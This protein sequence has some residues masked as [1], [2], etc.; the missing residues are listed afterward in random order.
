MLVGG[1]L[2]RPLVHATLLLA[3]NSFSFEELAQHAVDL[4]AGITDVTTHE[5]VVGGGPSLQAA[6]QNL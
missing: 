2:R 5:L 3:A 1:E 4:V 6:V